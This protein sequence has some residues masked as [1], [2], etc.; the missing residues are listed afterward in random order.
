[1]DSSS[2]EAIKTPNSVLECLLQDPMDTANTKDGAIP[3]S[4][5]TIR[6][7]GSGKPQG[8]QPGPDLDNGEHE[9]F[10][11]NRLKVI[12]VNWVKP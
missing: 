8:S 10:R 6:R 11:Q 9:H 1:M 2:H 4:T 3:K 5:S 12:A 7:V